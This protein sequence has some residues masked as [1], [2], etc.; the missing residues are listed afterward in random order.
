MLI[1]PVGW[2]AAGPWVP[3]KQVGTAA[4]AVAVDRPA[5]AGPELGSRSQAAAEATAGVVVAAVEATAGHL[6]EANLAV[7][8]AVVATEVVDLAGLGNV[9]V[10]KSD[11]PVV[12]TVA[13]HT[14]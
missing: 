11:G 2:L 9:G 8:A 6:A 14:D 3:K 10:S 13:E 5:A 4:A 7:A 1:N 12:E